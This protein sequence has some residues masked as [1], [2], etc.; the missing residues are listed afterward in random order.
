MNKFLVWDDHD[1]PFTTKGG[2]ADDSQHWREAEDGAGAAWQYAQDWGDAGQ[3]MGSYFM[4]VLS[5]AEARRIFADF[6]K[7]D[8]DSEAEKIATRFRGYTIWGVEEDEDDLSE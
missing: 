6:A 2:L 8:M 5:E 7:E 4:W 1:E 3:D